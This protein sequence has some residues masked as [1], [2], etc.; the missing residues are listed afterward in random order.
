[1][2]DS[3]VLATGNVNKLKE[4]REVLKDFPVSIQAL[5]DFDPMP[6]AIEDGATFAENAFK[7]AFH[8]ARRLGLPC[9]ADDSGLMVDALEGRPGVF[10][11]RYSGPDATDR[12]NCEKL[13]REM[14]GHTNRS[15]HFVCVLSLVTPTGQSLTWEGRCDGEI[16]TA[17]RGNSGF[18]YDPL[19]LYPESGKTLAEIPLEE[20][21]AFSHRGKALAAFITDF[22]RVRTWLR[23][24]MAER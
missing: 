6:E 15:A 9:M 21:S 24:Q 5:S 19:F 22:D 10:S 23:Q 17:P 8:Y 14:A 1:M 16:I 18:G 2:N 7:K 4:L 11:A 13:L 3:I 12:D 20:K